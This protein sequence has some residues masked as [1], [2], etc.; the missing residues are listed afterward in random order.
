MRWLKEVAQKL[1]MQAASDNDGE[2]G[3]ADL[4][5]LASQGILALAR[6]DARG[7]SVLP[8]GVVLRVTATEGSL[9]IL[10]V[11]AHDPAT[12]SEI[13]AR[14]LNERFERGA[15][16]ARRWEI[17]RGETNAIVVVEDASPILAMFVVE[18]ADRDGDRVPVGPGRREWRVGRGRW[19]ADNRLQN[20]I[21]LSETEAWL[22]KAA[23]IIRREGAGFE[24][25]SRDQGE[26]LVVVPR[27]GTPVR[28]AMTAAGRVTVSVGDRIEFHDGKSAMVAL[29]I[30]APERT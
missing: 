9:E 8:S 18:G 7:K 23:A 17:E 4:V 29:R 15:L 24:V 16:P 14:L 2:L 20:D 12:D 13:D 26:Y 22:S 6:R 30:E 28:P 3:G 21:V 5:V 19:H 27:D 25:E 1:G 11:W 10:R